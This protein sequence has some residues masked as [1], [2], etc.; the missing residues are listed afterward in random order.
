[1]FSLGNLFKFAIFAVFLLDVLHDSPNMEKFSDKVSMVFPHLTAGSRGNE[2]RE[3]GED[4]M[5]S[6][7]QTGL[8]GVFI[9]L[10]KEGI[11][12]ILIRRPLMF[13]LI[14]EIIGIEGMIV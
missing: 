10:E 9:P 8:E 3:F 14:V 5:P 1:M 4:H 13:P 7:E 12:D 2:F 11:A 6:P